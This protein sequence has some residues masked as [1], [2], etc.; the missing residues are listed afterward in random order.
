MVGFGWEILNMWLLQKIVF[1]IR[2]GIYV[3]NRNVSNCV[4]DGDFGLF[5]FSVVSFF[6]LLMI[7]F[8]RLYFL[9]VVML[10]FRAGI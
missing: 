1:K 8:Y 7:D 3:I 9:F 2:R 4:H 6:H 5:V 10:A